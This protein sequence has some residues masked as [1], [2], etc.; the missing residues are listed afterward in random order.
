MGGERPSRVSVAAGAWK[1]GAAETWRCRWRREQPRRRSGGAALPDAP[2]TP[3]RRKGIAQANECLMPR[4]SKTTL[5]LADMGRCSGG[6]VSVYGCS[7][8]VPCS[9]SG[10]EGRAESLRRTRGEAVGVKLDPIP[11]QRFAVN[12]GSVLRS[13]FPADDQSVDGQVHRRLMARGRG[14]ALVVVRA[15]ESRAHGEGEQEVCRAEWS[16]GGRR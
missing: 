1:L 7:S 8:F 13:P 15:R 12:V 16:L 11:V 10:T 4:D 14:R 9:W 2:A 3:A 6:A 5:N